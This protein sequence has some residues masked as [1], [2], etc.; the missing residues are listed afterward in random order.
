M[1]RVGWRA[2]GSC[3]SAIK[4]VARASPMINSSRPVTDPKLAVFGV[5]IAARPSSACAIKG[6]TRSHGLK[7]TIL[8]RL[9]SSCGVSKTSQ[10]HPDA[11]GE[12]STFAPFYLVTPV[13][14]VDVLLS[15][16]NLREPVNVCFQEKT[17]KHLLALSF[18][19]FDPI[20]DND[21]YSD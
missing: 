8:E 12:R 21:A 13:E 20:T 5:L 9:T 2:S 1:L 11:R 7:T 15:I 16:A 4:A 17:G 18:S 3:S 14:R 10:P 19:Q 6:R